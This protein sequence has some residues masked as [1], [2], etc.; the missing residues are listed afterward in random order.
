LSAKKIEWKTL[1]AGRRG[2]ATIL[3]QLT[4][5]ALAAKEL[6]G[7]FSVHSDGP[8]RGATFSLELPLTP[9]NARSRSHDGYEEIV[10]IGREDA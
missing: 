8:G 1:Y 5:D 9:P 7:I 2:A 3:T 4:G 6:G 10:G